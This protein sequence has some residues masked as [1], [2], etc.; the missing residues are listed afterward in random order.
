MTNFR[1]IIV[2]ALLIIIFTLFFFNFFGANGNFSALFSIKTLNSVI[3]FP[4][5][6]FS[7]ISNKTTDFFSLFARIKD[8]KQENER[9]Y[10]DNKKL[11]VENVKLK[12]LETENELLRTALNIEKSTGYDLIPARIIG[13]DPAALSNFIIIDKGSDFG[14]A[15]NAAVISQSGAFIGQIKKVNPGYSQFIPVVAPGSSVNA[16]TQDSRV[17]GILKGKYGLSLILE[18]VPQD[19]EIQI[20]EAVITSGVNDGFPPGILIGYVAD[21]IADANKPFKDIMVKSEENIMDI[22]WTYVIKN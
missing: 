15:E 6:F 20:N 22:E 2:I 8:L 19:K 7:I 16:I 4:I 17:R 14:V 5:K 21:I 1:S 9:F 3:I 11:I 10:L 18:L 13:K 12:E